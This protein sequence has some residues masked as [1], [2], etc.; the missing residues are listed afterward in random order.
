MKKIFKW[1]SVPYTRSVKDIYGSQKGSAVIIL[2]VLFLLPALM[3]SLFILDSKFLEVKKAEVDD[4]IVASA[5]AALSR[6]IDTDIAYGEFDLNK[7]ESEMI[8]KNH[9]KIGLKLDNN[10]LPQSSSKIA[11]EVMIEEF[12]IYNHGDT[13]RKVDY[14][15]RINYRGTVARGIKGKSCH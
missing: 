4:V 10:F 12:T 9:L 6:G 5:L 3:L 11:G 7:A 15:G 8:F 13:V 1:F 2:A 14:E